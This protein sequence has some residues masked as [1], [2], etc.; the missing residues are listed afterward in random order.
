MLLQQYSAL[1]NCEIYLMFI[2][3]Y[4]ILYIIIYS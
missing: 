3:I 2:Y 1:W 4:D